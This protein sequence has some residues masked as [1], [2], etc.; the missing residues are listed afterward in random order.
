MSGRQTSR[1]GNGAAIEAVPTIFVIDPDGSTRDALQELASSIGCRCRAYAS[2]GEFFASYV[3]SGPACLVL[4]VNVPDVNGLQIQ[5]R[6]ARAG[7]P[8]PLVYLTAHRDV[9]LAVEL[10]RGG[11]VHYLSKP[12]PRLTMVSAVQEALALDRAR[13]GAQRRRQRALDRLQAL[14]PRERQALQM[15]AEGKSNK[16]V[17]DALRITLRA[18]ELRRANLMKKLGL[19]CPMS[20]AI[21]AMR[22]KREGVL[23]ADGSQGGQPSRTA[24]SIGQ[25]VA[26]LL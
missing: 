2:A 11:A 14:T 22:A 15:I 9:W 8:L 23:T 7:D 26:G 16:Q 21:F 24:T 20:L 10:M 1:E 3:D 6:L 18:A 13:R 12:L 4:E 19:K 25:G 5:R 17:A